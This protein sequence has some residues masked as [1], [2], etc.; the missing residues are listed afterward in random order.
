MKRA[1]FAT[2][3]AILLL[4]TAPTWASSVLGLSIEDQTRLS[5]LVVTGE[6]VS[7]RGVV[8]HENGVETAV[9]LRVTE[10]FKGLA[11]PGDEVVFHTRSGE[12]DG[13]L[14]DAIGEARFQI[15]QEVLVF[16]EDVD[17]RLY[18]LGLSMGVWNVRLDRDGS[19]Y[20]TRALEEGLDIVGGVEVEFGPVSITDMA[21]RVDAAVSQP[22][23][24]HPW[25][26]LR[27]APDA[28]GKR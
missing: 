2:C 23:F 14:S 1:R 25:L 19:T 11:R 15:G 28:Q 26:Q 17:G 13:L 20:F 22:A 10:V 18:N 12:A 27:V 24:D 7:Q 9:T 3:A 6:V 4:L 21:R 16:I 5:R 8:H